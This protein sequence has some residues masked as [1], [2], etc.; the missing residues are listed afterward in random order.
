[1]QGTLLDSLFP[2]VQLTAIV[3]VAEIKI[4]G[5]FSQIFKVYFVDY[6]IT[7]APIFPLCPL[8]QVLPFP[9][10][11]PTLSVCPW[12]VHVSSLASP[13]PILFFTSPCLFCTY[14]LYFLFPAPFS[15]FSLLPLLTDNPPCDLHFC[16]SV[17]VLVVCLVCFC[18]LD[19]VVDSCVCCHFNVH[20]FDFFLFS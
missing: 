16:N 8:C 6:V 4:H 19:S 14:Q 20:S 15:P 3:T 12:V 5:T 9:P 7:V 1:M 18:F 11:I 13:F 10:A 2:L 17:P